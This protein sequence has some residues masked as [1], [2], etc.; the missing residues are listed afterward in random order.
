VRFT[1]EGGQVRIQTMNNNDTVVLI[2]KDTGIG[3]PEDDIHRVFERFYRV[4]QAHTTRG[5]GL[6]LPIAKRI[7]ERFDG[8]INIESKLDIGTTVK[9]SFPI[10]REPE[11]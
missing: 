11:D 3:I 7:I 4:D 8:T 1:P 5:F 10:L 9:L 2:I 6:G